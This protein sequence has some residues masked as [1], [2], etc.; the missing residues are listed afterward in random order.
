[1]KLHDQVAICLISLYFITYVLILTPVL[2]TLTTTGSTTS[3]LLIYIYVHFVHE[4][5]WIQ[6]VYI[7][8]F[9]K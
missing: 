5:S 8:L 9:V 7:P 6:N 1:M 3:N 2:S 4:I